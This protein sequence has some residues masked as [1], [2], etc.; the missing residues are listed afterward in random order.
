MNVASAYLN[1][2]N[3]HE[4]Y[5]SQPACFDKKARRIGSFRFGALLTVSKLAAETSVST[6]ETLDFKAS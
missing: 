2:K 4:I 1:G 5:M 3:T 6:L